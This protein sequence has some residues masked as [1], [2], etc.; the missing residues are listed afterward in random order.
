L[1]V[2]TLDTILL[3]LS[4]A[5]VADV[6]VKCIVEQAVYDSASN[7]IDFT[8]HTGVRAGEMLPYEFFWPALG[9]GEFPT[10]GEILEGNAGGFGPGATVTGTI[11]DCP[12]S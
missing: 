5:F 2:D 10:D 7:I 9:S 8:L 4:S 11:D 6:D 3:Q 12:E 1:N